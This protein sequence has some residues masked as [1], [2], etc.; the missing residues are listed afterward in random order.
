MVTG[1]KTGDRRRIRETF[2]LGRLP[3]AMLDRI[4]ATIYIKRQVC[5]NFLSQHRGAPQCTQSRPIPPYPA[6]ASNRHIRQ[7]RRSCTPGRARASPVPNGAN[8]SDRAVL[9]EQR[10]GFA[11]SS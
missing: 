3:T 2:H 8:T 6:W 7:R 1:P 4:R 10:L 9:T 5:L 11:N